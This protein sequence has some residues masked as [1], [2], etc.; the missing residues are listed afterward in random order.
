MNAGFSTQE[1]EHILL[2]VDNMIIDLKEQEELDG[3]KSKASIINLEGISKR[4]GNIL[5]E[6]DAATDCWCLKPQK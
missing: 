3:G 1:M 5:A 2:A 4:L 6:E